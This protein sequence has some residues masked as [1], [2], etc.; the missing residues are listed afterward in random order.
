MDY[1]CKYREFDSLCNLCGRAEESVFHV[2]AEYRHY[3]GPRRKYLGNLFG[4]TMPTRYSYLG[5]F[6]NL[7]ENEIG[8]F[9]KFLFIA[10]KIRMHSY[11]EMGLELL[12]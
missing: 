4:V 8:N 2:I 9:A 5:I 1:A 7:S 11:G 3:S 6:N 10:C 12:G